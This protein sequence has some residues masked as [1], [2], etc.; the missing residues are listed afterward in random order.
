M[1]AVEPPFVKTNHGTVAKGFRRGG[2]S[3]SLK[4]IIN[5]PS[6]RTSSKSIL[7]NKKGVT[8]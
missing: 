5:T 8:V 7:Y 3:I 1:H 2:L 4:D 6:H